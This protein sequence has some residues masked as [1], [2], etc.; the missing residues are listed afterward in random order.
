MIGSLLLNL[1]AILQALLLPVQASRYLSALL[2]VLSIYFAGGSVGSLVGDAYTAIGMIAIAVPAVV[3]L[4]FHKNPQRHFVLLTTLV[5]VAGY[6][7]VASRNL[8]TLA[9]SLEAMSLAAA[10]VAFYPA[11]KEKV[12]TLTTYLIFSV[13]AAVLLFSGLAFYF[14]GTNGFS[15]VEFT[16]T[17]TAIVG[18]SL[19]LASIMIKIAVTP[20]HAWA[21]DVYS[22][23]STSAALYLSN[24]VKAAAFLALGILASGPLKAAFSVGYWQ[25]LVPVLALAA[26][27][28]GVGAGGMALSDRAKRLLAFSSIAHAGFALLAIASPGP[29]A[30]AILAYYALAYSIAN[31]IAFSSV[32][33][34]KGEEDVSIRGL[35]ALYKRPLTALAFAIA[36]I[37]LLGVPPTAGFNAKLFALFSLLAS[38][39]IPYAFVLAVALA[40]VV[41]TAATGYG[42]AKA[43]AAVARPPEEEAEVGNLSLEFL[44]WILAAM[45]LFL[46]FFPTLPTPTNLM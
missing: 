37:S 42:Y 35:S 5:T 34:I 3:T 22:L 27:S 21:V 1:L 39:Q 12:R 20:M 33:L 40:A 41:F 15:L 38:A 29:A 17:P 45:L 24:A 10:A 43:I 36:M 11:T 23:S 6:F 18:L 26:I 14:A 7:V 46:Y 9:M 2:L 16:Q 32:L 30:A 4:L 25:V 28:V 44:L 8:A 13:F 31:T 19:I